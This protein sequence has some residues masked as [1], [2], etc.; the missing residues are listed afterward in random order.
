[1]KDPNYNYY[2]TNTNN[3]EDDDDANNDEQENDNDD[4]NNNNDENANKTKLQLQ[5]QQLV[6][7]EQ[8]RFGEL[9]KNVVS[10]RNT[11]SVFFEMLQLKTWEII[12]LDQ[13]E[14]YNGDI[15]ISPGFIQCKKYFL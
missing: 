13:D 4:D 2:Y 14:A 9:T 6:L 3:A 15:T 1:M 12:D 5:Q 8:V 7:P 11:A 10:R